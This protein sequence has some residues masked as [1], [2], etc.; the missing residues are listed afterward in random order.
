MKRLMRLWGGVKFTEG[1]KMI[2]S[3]DALVHL[4]DRGGSNLDL[5]TYLPQT[6]K[7][8]FFLIILKRHH[9]NEGL[10]YFR[11]VTLCLTAC[12]TAQENVFLVTQ[13]F[14]SNDCNLIRYLLHYQLPIERYQPG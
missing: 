1:Q 8:L 2:N 5:T 11:I 10:N 9:V 6:M 7:V 13:N 12:S 4:K 3:S 14:F